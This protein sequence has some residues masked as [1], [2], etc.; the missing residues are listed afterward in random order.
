MQSVRVAL[1]AEQGV[2]RPLS[3]NLF[4]VMALVLFVCLAVVDIGWNGPLTATA[5]Q[6]FVIKPAERAW[7][8]HAEWKNYG[9]PSAADW[10]L[11]VVEVTP[12]GPFDRA[13]I[14]TGF[15]FGPRL[16]ATGGPRFG[17]EYS[18]FANGKTSVRVRMV[19]NPNALG[20]GQVYEIGR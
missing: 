11:T 16:S 7:G 2:G 10:L 14:K 1:T 8:F 13:G 18:V 6:Y 15:A 4:L 12:G 17:G 20:Q 3:R 9:S 5:A 19:P